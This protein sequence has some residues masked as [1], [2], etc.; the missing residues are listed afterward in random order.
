MRIC[1]IYDCI[2]P[3]TVG[4]A[5][6]WYRNLAERLVEEGHE[7]T[8]LTLC[9]WDEDPGLSGFDVISVGPRMALY[10]QRGQRRILPTLIFGLGVFL[11]LLRFGARYDA[12]H[13]ASFPFFSVLAAAVLRR[14]SGYRLIV[15]WH[16]VWTRRY[17]REYLGERGGDIGWYIQRLCA[18]CEQT[19]FCFSELHSRRLRELGFEGRL[20]VL[21]GEFRGPAPRCRRVGPDAP[22]VVFAGRHI[23]EK[24]VAALVPA[25][26]LARR[27]I[28]DLRAAIL[29]DGPE[30][31][32]V[33]ASV[34][35][36][37][38]EGVVTVPGF[39]SSEEVAS[40][41][42]SA[43]CLVLPS[44]REGYG[45]VVVEAAASGTPSVVVAGE[46]NAAVELIEPGENGL[47]AA[48]VR[49]DDLA[50][51]I[52]AIH[53]RGDGFRAAT[54]DWYARNAEAL[55]LTG[56]LDRL[57]RAYREPESAAL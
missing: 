29:G 25:I 5:E 20:E 38:L 33:I 32:Q 15:D 1:L 55:S 2:Y 6:R 4:G 57:T 44:R 35:Q 7:I 37:H 14:A 48:S 50:A 12:V 26:A 54:A 45:M 24:Q 31:A 18:R 49:P 17:W 21:R 10:G 56:S 28:P 11:H 53:R 13:T 42:G 30:R 40:A 9:Q 41:I 39:V 19:A 43:T 16:E 52:C 3:H 22:S 46:D 27:S 23:P 51:A 36:N 34:R 8:Y 47:V